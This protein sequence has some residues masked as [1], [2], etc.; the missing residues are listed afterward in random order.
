MAKKKTYYFLKMSDD[1]FKS[2]EI[3]LLRKNA[4]GD[5]YALI[6]QR[7]MILSLMTDGKLYF[8]NIGTSFAEEVALELDE[9]VENVKMTLAYLQGK[10]LIEFS[11]VDNSYELVQVPSLV[12][13]ETNWARYKAMSREAGRNCLPDVNQESTYIEKESEID[14]ELDKEL[15]KESEQQKKSSSNPL[16][17]LSDFYQG[18]F[19]VIN[20]LVLDDLNHS[21]NDFGVELTLEAMKRTL[22]YQKPFSYALRIL[23]AW[24]KNNIKTLADV[25]ADDAKFERTKGKAKSSK[26]VK[27]APEWSQKKYVDNTSDEQKAEFEAYKAKRKE[28]KDASN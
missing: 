6:Y 1:F 17:I 11:E 20:P 16:S 7:I 9:T 3:K 13:S 15:D 12:G 27:Q 5:T 8:E 23:K 18:N 2:K 4:G 21:L 14:K 26:V 28:A 25:Q 24:A 10:K 19:G 22:R